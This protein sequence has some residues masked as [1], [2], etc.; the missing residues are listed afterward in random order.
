MAK[1]KTPVSKHKHV[2]IPHLGHDVVLVDREQLRFRSHGRCYGMPTHLKGI[3]AVPTPAVFSWA[4]KSTLYGYPIY[5][6]DQYGDCFYTA[7]AHQVQT[8]TANSLVE[9]AFD[10]KSLVA[11]YLQISAGDNG[12]D[13][14]T[15][16]PEWK[17]GIIGPKGP[18]KILDEMTVDPNDAAAVAESMYYFC[19]L[20]YTAALPDAWVANPKPG[21]TW[22]AG[23][24]DP[25]NGHAMHLTGLDGM[26][27]YQLQTWGFNPPIALTYAGL[28]G[29]D[30]ELIVAFS[31]EM[32]NA[33]GIS[34]AGQTYDQA[35]AL[36]VQRGGAPLPP[37]PFIPPVQP[38]VPPPGPPPVP[39]A[40][41]L[42]SGTY[43][44]PNNTT[45][46]VP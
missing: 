10:V 20:L 3:L 32:F 23:T 42:A 28:L 5:G 1:R 7:T 26:G 19:G 36:W 30:P 29:S 2:P 35:A 18:H 39:P 34:P 44:V 41:Q 27:D 21:D 11:R 14:A 6:N 8:W 9:C 33:K 40:G 25:Q 22:D 13:D 37:S 4:A 31:L 15:M 16:M 24:P 45:L 46:I 38:P 43:K 17:G 12:L